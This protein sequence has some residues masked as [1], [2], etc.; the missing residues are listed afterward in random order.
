[1]IALTILKEAL[2][3][4]HVRAAW[5]A[6]AMTQANREADRQIGER[7]WDEALTELIDV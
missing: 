4:R 5:I 1:M 7:V 3:G 6:W 2:I